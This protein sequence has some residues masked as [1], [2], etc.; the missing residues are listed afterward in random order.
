MVKLHLCDYFLLLASPGM[1]FAEISVCMK[2]SP[3]TALAHQ[4]AS[5]SEG[6]QSCREFIKAEIFLDI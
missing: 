1:C 3:F 4:M 2:N 6:R 5:D